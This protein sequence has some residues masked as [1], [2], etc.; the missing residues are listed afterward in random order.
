MGI[1]KIVTLMFANYQTESKGIGAK[2]EL[3]CYIPPN[4]QISY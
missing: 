3:N 1:F 2:H 4:Y